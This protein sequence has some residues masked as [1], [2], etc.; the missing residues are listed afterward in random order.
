MHVGERPQHWPRMRGF[1]RYFGLISGASSYY[2]IIE[3]QPRKR[4]M[5]LDDDPWSPPDSGFI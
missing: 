1:E 3:N 2:E 5:A 4:Q